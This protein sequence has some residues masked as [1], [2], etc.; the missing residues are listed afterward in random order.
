[1]KKVCLVLTL[2][3]GLF[4]LTGCQADTTDLDNQIN[5]LNTTVSDLEAQL[6]EEQNDLSG[7]YVGYSWKGESSGKT[8]EEASQKIETTL[9]LDK[10]G[11]ILDAKILFWKLKDGSWYTRQ[12]GTARVSVDLS[13]T[14][15]AATPGASYAKGTSMFTIDT[16][17]FMSLYSVVVDADGSAALLIV[18]P[19][20]RYQF[21][22][23]L[24]QGYDY[25]TTVGSVTV[26]GTA[27]GFI[28]T[29]RTSGSGVMKPDAWS[30][31]TGKNI[32]NIAGYNHVMVDFG[33]FEGLS[34]DSTMQELLESLGV[35]FTTGAPDEFALDYGRHSLGGWQGNYEAIED[36][37]IGMN[38]NDI[39]SLVD[40]ETQKWGDA[41][42]DD[43]FFG[44]DVP[45]GATKTAQ[46]S[47]D[48]IAG[49]T[50]RMSRESTSFQ[51][52]LVAAGILTEEEVVK[53]RF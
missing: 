42:N 23:S 21:E 2:A 3:L 41:V 17:D 51:R 11:N 14:P 26:D 35:M 46:D 30:E 19:T 40:W 1:M 7:T 33:V 22:I 16:H 5:E 18:D 48:G 52:A 47:F 27:G 15:E 13:V 6:E 50:V 49:A 34:A 37:L 29:V 10:D 39:T 53:G 43:N 45:A 36:Y 12:D 44:I 24:P 28:P 38:V 32:F 20:T 25:S 4:V 8:L 31:L 9:V